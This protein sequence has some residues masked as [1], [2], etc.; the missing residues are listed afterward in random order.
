[1][2]RITFLTILFFILLLSN[3]ENVFAQADAR[4]K[5]GKMTEIFDLL[6]YEEMQD[7]EARRYLG[8]ISQVQYAN[9][10]AIRSFTLKT[11]KGSVKINISPRLYAQRIKANDAAN[12]PTLVARNQKVTVDSFACSSGKNILAMYILA[13]S[14]PGIAD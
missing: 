11:T 4:Y 14:E 6:A 10:T 2:K 9:E 8:T 5:N 13:G 7:C 3:I 12:L 1:M